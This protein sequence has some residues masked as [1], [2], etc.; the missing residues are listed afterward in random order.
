[1][2]PLTALSLACNI[3]QVIEFGLKTIS[4]TRQTYRDGIADDL[5]DLEVLSGH[6]GQATSSIRESLSG[7]DSRESLSQD[8]LEIRDLSDKCMNISSQLQGK[9]ASLRSTGG[10]IDP[11]KRT[12]KS[13][14]SRWTITKLQ[15]V[16]SQYR[17]ILE[18]RILFR[19]HTL[20]LQGSIAYSDDF[21]NLE[22]DLQRFILR[23][24][25]GQRKVT[26][27]I[28]EE[29]AATKNHITAE[30]SA[31]RAAFRDVFQSHGLKA[32]DKAQ[33]TQFLNSLRFG[34]MNARANQL[35]QAHQ[36]TFE[37][38]FRDDASQPWPDFRRWLQSKESI[39]WISGKAGS[40]KSTLM[41]FLYR[42]RGT[43]TALAASAPWKRI[44][45][46]P[47]FFWRGGS[48]EQRSIHGFLCSLAYQLFD[49]GDGVLP[50]LLK[51][52]PQFA[53]KFTTS[54]W[55]QS[56]LEHTLNNAT[57]EIAGRRL[58]CFFI[59][60]LDELDEK[61]DWLYLIRFIQQLAAMDNV[62]VCVSSRPEPRLRHILQRYPHLRL[63][64]LNKGDI[65]I[66]VRSTLEDGSVSA[67]IDH[68]GNG[69]MDN[70]ISMILKKADGVFLWVVLALK[71]ILRGLSHRDTWDVLV[72]RLHRLPSDIEDLYQ[73]MWRRL[74]Q[75]RTLYQREA[76]LFF[77][78]FLKLQS[79]HSIYVRGKPNN[80]F[81]FMAAASDWSQ[82]L[83]NEPQCFDK[84]DRLRA[85]CIRMKELV[86]SRC[87]GLLEVVDLPPEVDNGSIVPMPQPRESNYDYRYLQWSFSCC[88]VVV[89]HRSAIDFLQETEAGLEMM[90]NCEMS[91]EDLLVRVMR[92]TLLSQL[93][94]LVNIHLPDIVRF[95]GQISSINRKLGL[96][97]SMADVIHLR[98]EETTSAKGV[99]FPK[100]GQRS[101]CQLALSY[102]RERFLWEPEYNATDF[103]GFA[104][105]HDIGEYYFHERTQWGSRS[106]NFTPSYKDYLLLCASARPSRTS[107]DHESYLID[108]LELGAN[109]ASVHYSPMVFPSR[110]TPWTM[111]LHSEKLAELVREIKMFLDRGAGFDDKMVI[112]FFN[113]DKFLLVDELTYKLYRYR[114]MGDLALILEMNALFLMQQRF[115]DGLPRD[116][117]GHPKC[118]GV[119]PYARV[120]LL[121][122]EPE[123]G[124]PLDEATSDFLVQAL[125]VLRTPESR[126]DEHCYYENA[127]IHIEQIRAQAE[128]KATPVD[129]RSF[130]QAKGYYKP[131][132]DPAVWKSP[133]P[134]FRDSSNDY[135][136]ITVEEIETIRHRS[137]EVRSVPVDWQ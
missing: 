11:L 15:S 105:E 100:D 124:L 133:V 134:R 2:D 117:K 108:L 86:E 18:T 10:R 8:D 7:L 70:I 106:Q 132:E 22:H 25:E 127:G 32:A 16:L 111:L 80:L 39:Y 120:W 38:A 41:K 5:A 44:L 4:I 50:K 47:F 102:D 103:T 37:W 46:V 118:Q 107:C 24:E 49:T 136:E 135:R 78:V 61:E 27:L 63:Q 99:F 29:G 72:N 92:A 21:A 17:T 13:F 110:V 96:L 83:H 33:C 90:G 93:L 123:V 52:E 128:Q 48:P 89:I 109:P 56:E 55:S 82:S 104:L 91:D 28:A 119:K 64:D 97:K 62:K 42:H 53:K 125:A 113:R 34:T 122:N 131:P 69:V 59:D 73:D 74:N 43:E 85:E 31:T 68:S 115:Q 137:R 23:L 71:D 19:L 12:V 121:M 87:A 9:I 98:N 77:R 95:F 129:L 94:G 40:G 101:I 58:I 126:R 45:T 54:D 51:L 79:E 76:S 20:V 88:Q 67:L 60:G 75:D 65:E 3:A 57:K 35:A 1:M 14:L 116:L 112:G 114:P 84:I 30:H 66:Y 6:L 130:L 26:E 81:L 36:D